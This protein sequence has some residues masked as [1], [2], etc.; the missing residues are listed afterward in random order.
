MNNRQL[1]DNANLL[2]K[3]G[4]NN[5][6]DKIYDEL[7]NND[8]LNEEVNF[9]KALNISDSNSERAIE[10]FLAI[11]ERNPNAY[12]V[13]P[14]IS[15]TAIRNDKHS[16]AISTFNK[17]LKIIPNDLEVIYFRAVHIGST[18]NMLQALLDFYFVVDNS[19]MNTNPSEFLKHQIATDIALCKTNLRNVTINKQ[20]T[21]QIDKTRYSQVAIKEYQYP[22]PAKLFGNENYILEFGKMM[23]KT[24]KEIL[25]AQPDYII[26]C[27]LNLENFCVSEEIVEMLKLKGI[28]SLEFENINTIK[29]KILTEQ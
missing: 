11:F 8:P 29:L 5:I 14:N 7:L 9:C 27:V 1:I 17:I 3:S 24:I 16:I 18:G 15:A 22:L 23:G 2:R 6:A 28:S 20:V 10:L 21:L 4:Q 25:A 13:L 19:A 12:S 26:W